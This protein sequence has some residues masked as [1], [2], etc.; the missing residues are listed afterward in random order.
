[1]HDFRVHF[2]K[3]FQ[4]QMIFYEFPGT[5]IVKKIHDFPEGVGTRHIMDATRHKSQKTTSKASQAG[6]VVP[7]RHLRHVPPDSIATVVNSSQIQILVNS[8]T[9]CITLNAKTGE[10]ILVGVGVQATKLTERIFLE[11]MDNNASN[12]KGQKPA[13]IQ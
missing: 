6:D 3:T 9:L 11:Y 1:M 2:S 10:I 4:D 13:T 5:G 8:I 7:L 12:A